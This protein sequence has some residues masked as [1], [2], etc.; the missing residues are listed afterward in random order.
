M[1]ERKTSMKTR[2]NFTLDQDTAE[3]LK[4]L[5]W[6]RHAS[7]SQILTDLI[8]SAKVSNSQLRGQIMMELPKKKA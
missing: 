2:M 3:R 8:W 4:Q 5:A 6:E 1:T 7:M